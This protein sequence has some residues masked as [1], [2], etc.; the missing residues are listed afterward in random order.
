[1]TTPIL[2]KRKETDAEILKN[3]S[4]FFAPELMSNKAMVWTLVS[5]SSRLLNWTQS[6]RKAREVG[7]LDL[8]NTNAFQTLRCAGPPGA[9]LKRIKMEM[10]ILLIWGEV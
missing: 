1:M 5:N 10:W 3:T 7:G 6:Q 2:Q 8:L 4:V 9:L